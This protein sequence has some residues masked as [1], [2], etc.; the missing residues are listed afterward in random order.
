[1]RVATHRR[2]VDG[3][4]PAAGGHER[5]ELG[6]DDRQQGFRDGPAIR[7]VAARLDSARERVRTGNAGLQLL[8]LG[9]E[10]SKA[11]PLGDDAEPVRRAELA[12]HPVAPALVVGRRAEPA[13]DLLVELEPVEEGVEREVEVEAGLLAVGDHVDAGAQLVADRRPDR[14]ANR[15]FA[16]VRAELVEVHARQLEPARERVAAD[17]RR[18]DRFV[19]HGAA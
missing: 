8:A 18:T 4:D 15:L 13:R 9:R 6:S 17:H 14:I 10:R 3:D 12:D 2:L 1:M 5:L 16:I 7:I 19:R 11:L